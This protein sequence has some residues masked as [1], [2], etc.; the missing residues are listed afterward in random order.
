MEAIKFSELPSGDRQ[1]LDNS[2]GLPI[3]ANKEN[4]LLS[5]GQL[6]RQIAKQTHSTEVLTDPENVDKVPINGAVEARISGVADELGERIDTVENTANTAQ[7]TATEAK[8]TADS[9]EASATSASSTANAASALAGEAKTAADSASSTAN[10]A[11]TTATTAKTT[12]DSAL[13][14]AETA[15]TSATSATELATTAKTTADGAKADATRYYGELNGKAEALMTAQQTLRT[16]LETETSARETAVSGVRT[17]LTSLSSRVGDIETQIASGEL[18]GGSGSEVETVDL[19]PVNNRL[20]ALESADTD[21]ETRLGTLE[22]AKTAQAGRITTL[23]TTTASQATAISEADGRISALEQSTNVLNGDNESISVATAIAE[24]RTAAANAQTSAD[25]ARSV[26]D[27][28]TTAAESATTLANTANA[29][30]SAA[31]IAA[32]TAQQTANAAKIVVCAP[33]QYSLELNGSTGRFL[34][35]TTGTSTEADHE[36]ND[37]IRTILSNQSEFTSALTTLA[38]FLANNT[39]NNSALLD[40]VGQVLTSVMN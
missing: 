29:T 37:V 30:A 3:I 31:Q 19:T 5:W 16:D 34:T 1:D 15:Q 26:A 4:R 21:H 35:Y 39:D 25:S 12:A 14:M 11:N 23:E 38:N 20:T 2:D 40:Q 9:A 7:T 27:S 33:I 13:A 22:T 18:G 24:V 10:L 32:E 36:L 8:T 17:D 28:A 6:K